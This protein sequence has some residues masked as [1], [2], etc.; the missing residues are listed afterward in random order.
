M[1]IDGARGPPGW[2]GGVPGPGLVVGEAAPLLDSS[3]ARLGCHGV[4]EGS[5]PGAAGRLSALFS[6]QPPLG[7]LG[8]R[9]ALLQEVQD[10]RDQAHHPPVV[11]ASLVAAQVVHLIVRVSEGKESNQ[12]SVKPD[13]LMSPSDTE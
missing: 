11:I 12:Q 5:C 9:H 4:G 2:L 6:S 3:A 7:S 8:R 13:L 10:H 1:F